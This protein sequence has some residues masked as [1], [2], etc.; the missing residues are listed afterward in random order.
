[1]NS[2]PNIMASGMQF[3]ITTNQEFVFVNGCENE[4]K[5]SSEIGTLT[6]NGNHNT[7][8]LRS[9]SSVDTL[10]VNGV[11][12]Q[13]ES[14]GIVKS[15]SIN[16]LFNDFKA[17]RQNIPNTQ[18]RVDGSGGGICAG[19]G[20]GGNLQPNNQHTFHHHH[21]N[22]YHLHQPDIANSSMQQHQHQIHNTPS[23]S[24][25]AT[26]GVQGQQQQ[27]VVFYN[28][29]TA[30]HN[31]MSMS[32]HSNDTTAT[33]TSNATMINNGLST[34]TS[35]GGG[36]SSG[37]QIHYHHSS[38]SN[39]LA[40][41]QQAS[42]SSSS[43]M[44]SNF[45][46]SGEGMTSVSSFG[47]VMGS[48]MVTL[49]VDGS[50]TATAANGGGFN[51]SFGQIGH[52][53]T[54]DNTTVTINRTPLQVHVMGASGDIGSTQLPT[55]NCN[56]DV[57]ANMNF[58]DSMHHAASALERISSQIHNIGQQET[59]IFPYDEYD[60]EEEGEYDDDDYED[61]DEIEEGEDDFNDG[62]AEEIQRARRGLIESIIDEF[63]SIS[64]KQMKIY[65]KQGMCY[66]MSQCTIC[67]EG[68]E[69]DEFVKILPCH[70][71]FHKDCIGTWL[72]SNPSCPVCK[73]SI[74]LEDEDEEDDE[75]EY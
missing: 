16:G 15:Y 4:I 47:G 12:N 62:M 22:H 6:I 29:Q 65:Q 32:N 48:P 23:S 74:V 64:F 3:Q 19:G 43:A 13:I 11:S 75:D 31:V 33:T 54:G 24:I 42:H 38:R 61:E 58:V 8:K 71:Y 30:G 63:T 25:T 39:N 60:R 41:N 17:K 9:L 70:H 55:L 26:N 28:N 68:F 49:G 2:F 18:V 66:E 36:V 46:D 35:G 14:K 34:D 37:P 44:S 10:I 1:M 69:D 45:V 73:V 52:N 20:T 67:L 53:G 21:H 59:P 7:V 56:F 51:Y 40:E 5:I 50:L 72:I 57:Q 27:Q